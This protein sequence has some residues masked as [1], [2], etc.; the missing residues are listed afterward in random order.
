MFTRVEEINRRNRERFASDETDRKEPAS[1]EKKMTRS[2]PFI[3]DARN[4]VVGRSP[5]CAP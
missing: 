4:L 5:Y 2:V 3:K 1:V